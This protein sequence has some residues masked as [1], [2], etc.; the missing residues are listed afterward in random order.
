MPEVRALDDA[1]TL[2]F[3]HDA[4]SDRRQPVAVPETPIYLD[5]L[6]ADTPLTGGL[7]P[8]LGDRA[9]AH[10]DRARLSRAEPAGDPRR[11]Q[12]SGFRLSLGRRRFIALDKTEATKALTRLRRQWFNKRKSVTALLREVMYNQ[13]VQ[14]TRQRRRQQG[15]RRRSRAPGARRRPCRLRLSDQPRSP[16]P[17]AGP[18]GRRGRRCGRSSGW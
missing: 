13:P 10:A 1:E 12:P 9:S 15:R 4:I 5:A 18:F 3:L 16:S 6:L 17:D 8:M 2:T 7:E 11:A 14:L